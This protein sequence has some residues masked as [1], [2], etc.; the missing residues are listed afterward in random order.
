MKDMTSGLLFKQVISPVSVSANTV[1][2][3]TVIVR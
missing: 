2:V 3:G 1:Q